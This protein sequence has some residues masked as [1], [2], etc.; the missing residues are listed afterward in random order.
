MPSADCHSV[1]PWK[2]I[3]V[4]QPEGGFE[5]T[6]RKL[7]AT[8]AILGGLAATTVAPAMAASHRYSRHHHYRHPHRVA[9]VYKR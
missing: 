1:S 4:Y 7:L 5:Q 3:K 2:P 6:M 8:L 9:V